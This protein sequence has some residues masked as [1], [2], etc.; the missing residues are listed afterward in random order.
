MTLWTLVPAGS[1]L[2]ILTV[3]VLDLTGV[4][5]RGTGFR[6]Q[7]TGLLTM[8]TAVDASAFAH[9]HGWRGS[10]ILALDRATLA[11]IL[12]GFAIFIVG[13]RIQG[14]DRAK[15]RRVG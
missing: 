8:N 1:W 14:R 13:L 15:A 2:L 10:Q 12:A 7:A 5:H 3:L 6:W 9:H 4:L 11:V